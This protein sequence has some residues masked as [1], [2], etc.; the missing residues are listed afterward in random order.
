[1]N[2]KPQRGDR[3]PSCATANTRSPRHRSPKPWNKKQKSRKA[4]KPPRY[5]SSAFWNPAASTGLRSG[6]FH[7]TS[8]VCAERQ[9]HVSGLLRVFACPLRSGT[10]S[11]AE[12]PSPPRFEN[13]SSRHSWV[14]AE[15]LLRHETKA[16]ESGK[17]AATIHRLLPGMVQFTDT[18]V[19]RPHCTSSGGAC[20]SPSQS[21]GP[22]PDHAPY[23]GPH[24]R[25]RRCVP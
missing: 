19:P 3:S 25:Q 5:P 9:T 12:T 24:Q 10:H 21:T 8:D 7:F 23:R 15:A 17:D 16:Q 4:S 20:S 14:R 2:P 13:H 1:M 18:V 6:G 22:N 11:H